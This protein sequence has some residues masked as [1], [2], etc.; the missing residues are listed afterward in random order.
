M[1]FAPIDIS[2]LHKYKRG[3]FLPKDGIY[4]GI[5]DYLTF[6]KYIYI[7]QSRCCQPELLLFRT[8]VDARAQIG[9]MDNGARYL[10]VSQLIRETM[11]GGK[12]MLATSLADKDKTCEENSTSEFP[13]HNLLQQDR[14]MSAVWLIFNLTNF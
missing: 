10:V 8:L 11:E 1:N 7:F 14:V 2:T 4:V 5:L 3:I 9:A 12:N 6:T 13:L